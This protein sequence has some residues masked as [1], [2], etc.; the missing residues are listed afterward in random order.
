MNDFHYAISLAQTLYEVEGDM[1]D[2][3]EIGLVAYNFIG[4]KNI[5]L[6]KATIPVNCEDGS[7][8]LPCNVD[9]IEAV[10]FND[11]E[12]WNYTSNSKEYGDVQSLYTENYIESRKIFNNPLYLSGKYVQY[13]RVGN[14]L[15]VNK[16]LGKV[17]ILY[18]GL[19]LDDDGLPQINDKEAIA[20]AD[21]IAYTYFYKKAIRTNNKNLF[22][23][24][25]DLNRKWLFHCDAARVPEH[26]SQNEMDQILNAK[27]SW[28][29][30][31]YNKSYKP[32]RSQGG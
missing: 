11:L 7:I 23:L 30:K 16:S 29:R 25:Q 24:A 18:H 2:L 14:T 1:E 8:Q 12:D 22:E 17:T 19:L 5:R 21:Y 6:Y 3:E 27:T 10:T 9:I 28:D 13:E 4:N 15:Y 32:V 20:I 26:I 31:V